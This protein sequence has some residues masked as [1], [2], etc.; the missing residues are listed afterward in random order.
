MRTTIDEAAARANITAPVLVIRIQR[1][2]RTDLSAQ[3]LYEVTRGVWV[4]GRRRSKARY[5]LAVF[6]RIVREVYEIDAWHPAGTTEYEMRPHH[7]VD[8]PGRWEFTGHVAPD[9][10]LER[11]GWKYV[12]HLWD[13]GAANPISYVNC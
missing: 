10:V 7:H 3:S 9:D 5:A 8:R 2:Y 4:S 13:R 12:S 1:A 6:N 11:C